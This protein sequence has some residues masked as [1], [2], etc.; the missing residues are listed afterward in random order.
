[1]GTFS[2]FLLDALVLRH[3]LLDLLAEGLAVGRRLGSDQGRV[4]RGLEAQLSG[5]HARCLGE[6]GSAEVVA[7]RLAGCSGPRVYKRNNT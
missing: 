3:T 1:M 2:R 7:K 5:G 4:V 6:L